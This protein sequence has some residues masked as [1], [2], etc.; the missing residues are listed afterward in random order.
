MKTVTKRE[1]MRMLADVSDDANVYVMTSRTDASR[2][3]ESATGEDLFFL[4]GG[5][6]AFEADGVSLVADFDIDRK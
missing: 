3:M 6:T 4:L 1:L 2:A 5:N